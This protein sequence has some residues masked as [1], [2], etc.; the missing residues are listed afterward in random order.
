MFRAAR[1]SAFCLL[2]VGCTNNPYRSEEYGKNYFYTTFTEP[3]KHLDPAVSYSADE[4]E[5]IENI[6]EPPLQYHFLKRPYQ[7]EPLTA[8]EI[9]RPKYYDRDGKELGV[10]PPAED[11]RR[12][13][14]TLRI[15]TGIKYQ[16][17]PCFQA[18]NLS[19]TE[20][21][22]KGADYKLENLLHGTRTLRAND[23]VYQIKRLAHPRL[24]SP[25]LS[26]MEKYILGLTELSKTLKAELEKIRSQRKQ[27]AGLLYNQELDERN[28]PIFL[29]LDK[30]ELEGAKVVDELTWQITLKE[31][32]PQF[33]YWLAMPFFS[34]IPP[35]AGR[36][37]TQPALTAR[38]VSLDNR[39]IGT[40][41]YRIG[42]YE[43]HSQIELVRNENFHVETYP[44]EGDPGDREHGLLDDA[45]KK[46]PFLD[47]IIFKREKEQIPRWTKFLQGYYDT[48]VIRSEVF[49]QAIS[50]SATGDLGLS[51]EMK[52]MGIG[53]QKSIAPTIYYFGFNMDDGIVGGYTAERKKLRQA[54]SLA[55]SSEE[56]IQIFLNGR[57]IPAQGPIAPGIFGYEETEQGINNFIYDWDSK[58]AKP[59]RKS[60]DYAKKLLAEAGYAGGKDRE[61]RPLVLYYDTSARGAEGSPFLDWVR[62]QFA[63][64]NIGLQIRATDYNRFRGKVDKGN[65]Q[66]ISWGWNADYPD[67]EN[68][69][70]LLYGPYSKAKH[71]GENAVNY[72]NPEFNK[73]F[74]QMESMPDSPARLE[75][76]R[77]MQEIAREDSPWIWWY[78]PVSFALYH[79]W[80]HNVKPKALGGSMKYKRVDAFIREGKR[81][82]WNRPIIWPVLLL[83]GLML[84]STIPAFI[85]IYGKGRRP[86]TI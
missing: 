63:R 59:Q 49:D 8:E 29:D 52:K 82:E 47:K 7:L 35:E 12:A 80:Y 2:L 85:K 23:Y 44:S 78:N 19:L 31:K 75:I 13:T 64:L 1:V 76:I 33:V 21:L 55:V 57:G 56:Y 84:I 68:F 74:K 9:P 25:I 71:G 34:P 32:Y 65:F 66:I 3:P 28:N 17:H 50:L 46:L 22:F 86:P 39:P 43:E 81:S 62:K 6:Y 73:L 36:F 67:P 61:G 51:E 77:K 40:G 42:R 58:T 4:Y 30:F 41:P 38:G 79:E 24:N 5:L 69:L 54:I 27:E 26:T 72:D 18:V 15:K 37:Y 45:G 11:V 14:Y 53:L 83:L 16:N 10:D 70:F 20:A 48:S 60:I